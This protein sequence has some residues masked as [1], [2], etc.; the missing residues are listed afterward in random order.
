MVEDP[1]EI[2]KP[3][4]PLISSP[5]SERALWRIVDSFGIPRHSAFSTKRGCQGILN[6]TSVFLKM[7]TIERL[8]RIITGAIPAVPILTTSNKN[9]LLLSG[10]NPAQTEE[11]SGDWPKRK[12]AGSKIVLFRSSN[13]RPA[14]KPRCRSK[15]ATKLLAAFF[16]QSLVSYR[17]NHVLVRG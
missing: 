6:Q 4:A 1:S 7:R 8:I 12:P 3:K 11:N 2:R 10:K 9:Q 5:K 17:V 13:R 15:R 16:G 14:G